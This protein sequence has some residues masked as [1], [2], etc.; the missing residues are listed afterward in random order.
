M[1][2][3]L[4]E[5]INTQGNLVNDGKY[6]DALKLSQELYKNNPKDIRILNNMALSYKNLGKNNEARAIFLKIID[7]DHD[8]RWP[9]IYS[10]AGS[11]LLSLGETKK[12]I[13][14]NEIALKFNQKNHT[15]LVNLG[16]ASSDLG[17][18]TSAINYYKRSLE[19]DPKHN[20]ANY[21]LANIYRVTKN[22]KE[23]IKLYDLTNQRLSKSNQLE[24]IY[25]DNNKELFNEKLSS[26]IINDQLQPLIASLS[27]HAAIRYNQEDNYPFCPNPMDFICKFD[28]YQD[29][30]F[31]DQFLLNLANDINN[32]EINKKS[33]SLLKNGFQSSGNIFLQN[34][35]NIKILQN[36]VQDCLKSYYQ[37]F[38]EK[39]VALIKSWPKKYQLIGW[40]I[41]MQSNGSLMPHMHKEGWV[42]GSL[43]LNMPEN[44]SGDEGNIRFSLDGGDYPNDNKDYQE[45]I[46]DIKRGDLVMFPSSLFHSTIPFQ[47]NEN[48]ISFAFDLIP[49]F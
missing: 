3:T 20:E 7:L 5:K 13:E 46:V 23:A 2:K 34:L 44:R 32:A 31:N 27:S 43:Y 35:P 9:A 33:Q 16:I 22:Y 36:I 26:L 39:Q 40:V 4:E 30:R 6:N 25:K 45:K 47:S 42:S 15:A 49:K 11:L 41:I 19:I 48:R 17:D 38:A 37:N 1:N 21:N 10:N 29:D 24:C 12:S 8:S 18:I 14:A 28:L